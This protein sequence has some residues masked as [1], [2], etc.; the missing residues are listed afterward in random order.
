MSRLFDLGEEVIPAGGTTYFIF[1]VKV[2]T[3]AEPGKLDDVEL[4][5]RTQ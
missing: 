3:D 5:I 4:A 1:N 2:A